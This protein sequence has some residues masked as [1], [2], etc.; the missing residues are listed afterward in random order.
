MRKLIAIVILGTSAVLT[1]V[2]AM[3]DIFTDLDRTAPRGAVARPSD[4]A[5]KSLFDQINDTAPV[6]RPPAQDDVYPG[7]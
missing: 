7:E 2:P 3:A 1:S 4:V 5:A 6:R